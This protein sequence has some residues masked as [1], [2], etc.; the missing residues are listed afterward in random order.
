MGTIPVIE[1]MDRKDGWFKTFDD[2]PVAWIDTYDNLTPQWLTDKYA[3]IIQKWDTYNWEKL[4]RH[5]WID[6]TLNFAKQA[7]VLRKKTSKGGNGE[8][9]PAELPTTLT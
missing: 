1:T 5:W 6:W 3:E 4:T 9:T 7:E 2:L 8:I